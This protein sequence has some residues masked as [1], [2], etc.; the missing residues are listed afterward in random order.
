MTAR[1]LL[2]KLHPETFVVITYYHNN[3]SVRLEGNYKDRPVNAE[4]CKFVWKKELL[5]SEII[6]V[7]TT[8]AFGKPA[9]EIICNYRI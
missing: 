8:E 4:D 5:D 6:T 9:I 3:E 1:K 7:S 2:N